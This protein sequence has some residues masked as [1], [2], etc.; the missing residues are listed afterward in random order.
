MDQLT[1]TSIIN[2]LPSTKEEV[3]KFCQDAKERILAGYENPLKIAVQLKGFEEVIKTLRE[4]KDIKA[5]VLKE[6]LKEEKTFK[7]FGAELTVKEVGV[8]YDYSVCD[9]QEWNELNRQITELEAK[10]E[11][12]ETLLKSI[13]DDIFDSQGVQL[14]AP[15]KTSTTQVTVKLD[16]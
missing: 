2:V 4:D 10:K 16:K 5:V 13:K 14:K 8:K 7:R 12:R 3:R 1:T 15:I 9:D 6:A 11:A